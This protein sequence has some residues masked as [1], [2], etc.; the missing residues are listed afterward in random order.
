[1]Q[2]TS[3]GEWTEDHELDSWKLA[4]WLFMSTYKADINAWPDKNIFFSM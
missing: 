3:G 2:K 1:M 4:Y